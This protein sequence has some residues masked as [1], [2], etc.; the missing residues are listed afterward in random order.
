M[1][2][3]DTWGSPMPTDN[4]WVVVLLSLGILF[5]VGGPLLLTI[6]FVLL[7]SWA[8]ATF[9]LVLQIFFWWVLS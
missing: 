9:F 7:G 4:T 5:I 8:K 3:R 2:R 1:R 6:I